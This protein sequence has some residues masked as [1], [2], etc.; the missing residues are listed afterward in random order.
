MSDFEETEFR[1]P[2]FNQLERGSHLLWEPGQVFEKR[3]GV[4]RASMCI[5]DYFWELYDEY[6]PRAG[7][8]LNRRNLDFIWKGKKANK[9]L[10][11]FSLNLFIQA[12]RSNYSSRKKTELVKH[13]I[14][15]EHW[16]FNITRHQQIALQKLAVSLKSKALVVYAAPVFHK[17]QQLFNHT[18]NRTIIENSNFPEV[19]K[20]KGHKTWYFDKPGTSGV[21]NPDFKAVNGRPLLQRLQSMRQKEGEFSANNFNDNLIVLAN[22]INAFASNQAKTELTEPF[23][24]TQYA[25]YQSIIDKYLDEFDLGERKDLRSYMEIGT[26]SV[27]NKLDW[28]T[29]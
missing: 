11:D 21:A 28:L 5:N 6:S 1:G 22:N 2:L 16:Y 15:K 14:P 29:F 3:I 27:I 19:I 18:K 10:P 17:Q 23:Q 9:A 25:F 20:L 4:D 7:A 8:Y 12:K 24:A 26:F 13:G